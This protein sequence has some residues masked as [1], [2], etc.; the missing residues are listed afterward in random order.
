MMCDHGHSLH[1]IASQEEGLD[2]SL[3]READ[4]QALCYTTA[5]CMI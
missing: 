4:A 1:R 5:V 2:L 3:R